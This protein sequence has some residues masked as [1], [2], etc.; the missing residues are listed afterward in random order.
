VKAGDKVDVRDTEYVWCI[1]TVE[2]KITTVNHP[3]LLYIHF[4]VIILIIIIDNRDGIE[5]MMSISTK[6][7]R[8]WHHKVHIQVEQIF[9]SIRCV[10]IR[11]CSLAN[12]YQV[13]K[14][15]KQLNRTINR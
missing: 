4:E 9:L 13:L 5:D 1:G 6:T 3:P 15:F 8:D 14:Q 12:L 2:L 7:Q 10:L 11:T